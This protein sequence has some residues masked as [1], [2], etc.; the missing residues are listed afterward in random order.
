MKKK[1]KEKS[2]AFVMALVY[3]EKLIGSY[4]QP[5]T[6]HPTIY[7]ESNGNHYSKIVFDAL[8][9]KMMEFYFRNVSHCI[10][11]EKMMEYRFTG[12]EME[13]FARDF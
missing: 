13:W 7:R 8:Q 5:F 2:L 12:D 10:V 1:K 3:N 4:E 9:C 6:F 11:I